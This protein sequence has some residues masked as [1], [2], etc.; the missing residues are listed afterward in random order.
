MHVRDA[1]ICLSHNKGIEFLK[2]FYDV[3]EDLKEFEPHYNREKFHCR[4][5]DEI[6]F[7]RR[8]MIC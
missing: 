7:V 2:E 8:G 3:L 6:Q 5:G 1:Y 4:N